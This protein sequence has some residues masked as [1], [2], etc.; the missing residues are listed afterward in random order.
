MMGLAVYGK[1]PAKG[2]FLEHGLPAGLKPLLEGWLDA[3]LAEARAVL[4]AEWDRVWRQA[5][6]LRFWIGDGIWGAPVAGVMA[7]SQDRVGRRFP[8]VL[9]TLNGVAPPVIDPD[10]RWYDA[11]AAHL[12]GQLGL[13][14]LAGPA[15]LLAG[16]PEPLGV[17]DA[18]GPRAFWAVRPGPEVVGLLADITLTDHRRATETRSYWWVAGMAEAEVPAVF[19]GEPEPAEPGPEVAEVAEVEVVAEVVA[20]PLLEEAVW[21]VSEP[22]LAAEPE[23][24]AS[25]FDPPAGGYGLFQPPEPGDFTEPVLPDLPAAPLVQAP[26]QLWSQV[27]AGP[28]L[29]SGEV[30]AWFFRGYAGDA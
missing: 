18:P 12:G 15:A 13:A 21:A 17:D 28:G 27:W 20:E 19:A 1:H 16:A 14:D 22:V 6:M 24:D 25:P 30:L 7:A 8:L 5:P 4:G 26:R 11:A 23:A 9:L 10:Q 29:P 3:V 2:D